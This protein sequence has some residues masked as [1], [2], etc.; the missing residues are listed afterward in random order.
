MKVRIRFAKTGDLRFIGHLDFMRYVQKTVMRSGIA[1]IFTAGFNNSFSI[2]HRTNITRI[3]SNGSN[4]SLKTF[5]SKLLI[6]MN[7]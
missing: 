7:M 3:D 4:I 2:F 1:P 6:K 5:K